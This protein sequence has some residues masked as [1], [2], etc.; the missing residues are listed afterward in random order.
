MK[1][2]KNIKD[3]INFKAVFGDKNTATIKG[4]DVIFSFTKDNQISSVLFT[5][6]L[7]KTLLKFKDKNINFDLSSFLN[8]YK[9]DCR[10]SLA[11]NILMKIDTFIEKSFSLKTKQTN[12][13]ANINYD[14]K[15][16][17]LVKGA[18]ELAK[19]NHLARY[20]QIMPSNYLGIADFVKEIK[21]AFTGVNGIKVKVLTLADLKKEKMGL[22]QAVNKGS[23]EP[24]AM[25]VLEYLNAKNNNKTLALVGK[26]IMYDAGGYELK[27]SK[28][29]ADMNQDMTGAATVF[30]T[31]LALAKTKAKVNVVGFLPLAKNLINEKSMMVNDIYSACNGRTVEIISQDSEGRLILAD[32]IAYANKKY[33]ISTIMDIATLT[34]LSEI[35]YSDY[36]TPFWATKGSTANALMHASNLTG[37]GLISLPLFPDMFDLVNKSSKYADCANST[38]IREASNST[39]A[40]FLK[41]FSKCDDFVHF[42]VAGTN[43]FKK[44]PVNPLGLLFFIFAKGYFN[45]K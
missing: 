8:T 34:G 12:V 15:D 29:L 37:D 42:D 22:I 40:A 4:N 3:A 13:E 30:G 19:A 7:N 14:A 36:L 9:S 33:K 31:M 10:F 38:G 28:F 26:G 17:Q 45:D 16:A 39:A 25:V 27:P 43:M 23:D 18:I 20:Y 2:N 35:S 11:C 41:E 6:E 44:Y 5:R 1:F 32:A 21:K 24:A